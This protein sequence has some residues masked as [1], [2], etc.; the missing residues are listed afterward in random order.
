MHSAWIAT[1]GVSFQ[2]FFYL[3]QIA[4][5][6]ILVVGLIWTQKKSPQSAF[7]LREA[8]RVKNYAFPRFP[9]AVPKSSERP[10]PSPRKGPPLKLSG[11]VIDGPAHEVL[12][13]H[14]GASSREVQKAWRD[15]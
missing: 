15:L 14:P 10:R 13:V 4:L 8:D 6:A 2:N 11:I 9:Q 3:S 12:G 1:R 5:G 7:K